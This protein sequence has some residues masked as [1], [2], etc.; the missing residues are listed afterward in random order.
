MPTKDEY[1][2]GM[3]FF[4]FV[5]AELNYIG[6]NL[7]FFDSVIK[8]FDDVAGKELKQFLF[9]FY[10]YAINSKNTYFSS[11]SRF[12]ENKSILNIPDDKSMTFKMPKFM[13]SLHPRVF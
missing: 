4:P 1:T 9:V 8:L 7:I 2:F 10:M 5:A 13:N 11:V 12:F 6:K 3:K